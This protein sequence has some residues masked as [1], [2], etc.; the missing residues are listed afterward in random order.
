MTGLVIRVDDRLVHGQILYGWLQGWPADEVWL[1]NDRIANDPVER[2]LYLDLLAGV[3][4]SGILLIDDAIA[5][6]SGKKE[7]DGRILL[8]LESCTDLAR[9][10]KGGVCPTE[11]H[12][13]NLARHEGHTVLSSNVAVGP[14]DREALEQILDSGCNVTIRDLPS[15]SAQPLKKALEEMNT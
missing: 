7:V 6:F 5:R 11:A 1:A 8:V 4:P 14:Q 2:D 3:N 10:L 13:G 15:S 12:L 9:V